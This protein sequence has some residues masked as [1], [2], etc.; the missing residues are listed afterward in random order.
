MNAR[1]NRAFLKLSVLSAISKYYNTGFMQSLVLGVFINL[2]SGPRSFFPPC[3]PELPRTYLFE[4]P[5]K[6]H[7]ET[8]N[9]E[10]FLNS[11][12]ST[13]PETFESHQLENLRY[14]QVVN[15]DYVV[16]IISLY[17]PPPMTAKCL[18]HG[19][20]QLSPISSRP[21]CPILAF[22][23]FLFCRCTL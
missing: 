8:V 5:P 7:Q 2:S 6:I 11:L 12:L 13:N 18:F 20:H 3:G 9:F 4:S 21:R 16:C 19:E 17:F 10:R 23:F 22:P 1:T 14:N 15:D